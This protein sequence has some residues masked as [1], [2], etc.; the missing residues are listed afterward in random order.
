[1][2]NSSEFRRGVFSQIHQICFH[3]QGGYDWDTVYNMP[4]WLRKFTF[5]EIQKYH[6]KQNEAMQSKGKDS[7]TKSLVNED[8]TINAPDF[9]KASEPYKG[10]TSY[11]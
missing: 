5:S 2:D 9:A 4:I 8:G 11:K 1:M 7:N 10:K 6:E 3:G